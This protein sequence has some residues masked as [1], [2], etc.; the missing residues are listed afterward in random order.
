MA[1]TGKSA[2]RYR[3]AIFGASAI[4]RFLLTVLVVVVL[5][6]LGR[7]A[8]RYGY[9]IFNET[10][11]EAAPGEDEEV[12]IPAGS[13]VREIGV[14]LRRQGLIREPGI[15]YLQELF[16]DYH[17][18]LQAGTYVLNTS[19]KPSEMMAVMSGETVSS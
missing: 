10:A 17:G 1:D 4:L 11:M 6:F 9:S 15:F 16:S 3:N 2:R 7:T 19:M 8:Y 13:S 14:I 18:K 12:I 5:I